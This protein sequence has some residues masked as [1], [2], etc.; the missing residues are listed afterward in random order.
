MP[1]SFSIHFIHVVAVHLQKACHYWTDLA[2]DKFD[3]CYIRTREKQEVDFCVVREEVP[4][5][6]VECK[7]H[8]TAISK[9]LIK[10]ADVFVGASVFQVTSA[11][12]DRIV[13]GTRIRLMNVETFLSMFP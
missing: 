12:V 1:S 13:P 3:F 7:S 5:M 10:F 4:W 8:S 2:H 9:S 11:D 6:L